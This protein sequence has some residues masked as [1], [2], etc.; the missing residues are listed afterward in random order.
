[1][2]FMV[3]VGLGRLS[4]NSDGCWDTSFVVQLCD[5]I[6][7][8][9]FPSLDGMCNIQTVV[10]VEKKKQAV[11]SIALSIFPFFVWKW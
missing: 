11:N 8:S 3:K 5:D 4:L 9:W 7:L 6:S 10:M 1:M 2:C